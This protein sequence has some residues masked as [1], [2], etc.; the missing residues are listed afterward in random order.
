MKQIIVDN[1]STDYYIT[2]DGKCFNNKTGKYLKGQINCRNGY[3]S[4]IIKLPN[5]KRKRCTAHRLVATAYIPNPLGLPQ[6]NHIDGN[7]LNNSLENLEWCTAKENQ[8]HAIEN[9]LRKFKKVYCFTPN[10]KLVAIYKNFR[11]EKE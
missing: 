2:E 10:K 11:Y 7:K 9:E 3:F 5:G 4:Y 8:R 1:F 6:V